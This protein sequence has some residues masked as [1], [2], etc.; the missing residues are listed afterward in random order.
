[1]SEERLDIDLDTLWY[2]VFNYLIFHYNNKTSKWSNFDFELFIEKAVYKNDFII[3]IKKEID[4]HYEDKEEIFNYFFNELDIEQFNSFYNFTSSVGTFNIKN[5]FSNIFKYAKLIAFNELKMIYEN[6]IHSYS[7]THEWDNTLFAFYYL[8]FVDFIN[9]KNNNYRNTEKLKYLIDKYNKLRMQ[10]ISKNLSEEE[11]KEKLESTSFGDEPPEEI[12]VNIIP[13]SVSFVNWLIKLFKYD[14]DEKYFMKLSK[15]Q[16]EFNPANLVGIKL[17]NNISELLK[18]QFNWRKHSKSTKKLFELKYIEQ[19][20]IQLENLENKEDETKRNDASFDKELQ[21]FVICVDTSSSMCDGK[22]IDLANTIIA[23]LSKHAFSSKSPIYLISFSTNSHFVEI[24]NQKEKSKLIHFLT[25]PYDGGTD[26]DIALKAII[27]CYENNKNYSRSK[28]L[29]ISDFEIS[30]VSSSI[31]G[32]I[33]KLKK[34]RN[35]TFI[36][37]KL[38][39]ESYWSRVPYFFDIKLNF[40]FSKKSNVEIENQIRRIIKK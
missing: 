36:S 37:L 20:L 2:V 13:K 14:F 34:E 24:K 7:N 6:V 8:C 9:K 33:R 18:Y 21:P 15:E 10:R 32:K 1:M 35:L 4:W 22:I 12:Y 27:N 39:K 29:F 31:E 11:F 28:L 23:Q 17:G 19:K 30:P 25:H 40:N 26:I 38:G 5:K 3:D 16:W